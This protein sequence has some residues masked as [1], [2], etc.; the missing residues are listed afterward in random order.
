VFGNYV[1]CLLFIIMVSRQ[2]W[3]RIVTLRN[4]KQLSCLMSSWIKEHCIAV[5]GLENYVDI[6]VMTFITVPQGRDLSPITDELWRK[7]YARKF[8]NDAVDMVK[9][10]MA[11]RN[12][13][14][15]WK[16]LYQVWF[17]YHIKQN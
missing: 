8:G 2:Y 13:K 5:A 14:F 1:W 12:C 11:N 9:E 15:K 6:E 4:S 17:F 3:V 7:C 16:Q 10:R